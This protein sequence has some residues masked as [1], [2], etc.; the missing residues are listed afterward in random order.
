MSTK[1][2]LLAISESSGASRPFFE[3]FIRTAHKKGPGFGVGKNVVYSETFYAV[4]T[5]NK[6]FVGIVPTNNGT[7]KKK[8]KIKKYLLWGESNPARGGDSAES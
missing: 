2:F 8:L 3:T 1:L 6:Y 5:N 4:P 7:H